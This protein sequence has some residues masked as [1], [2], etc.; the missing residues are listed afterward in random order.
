MTNSFNVCKCSGSCDAVE[1]NVTDDTNELGRGRGNKDQGRGQA[2]GV[3]GIG[4]VIT[5]EAEFELD[6]YAFVNPAEPMM[7]LSMDV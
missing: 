5:T 4:F 1:P 3:P 2:T 6:T 7:D